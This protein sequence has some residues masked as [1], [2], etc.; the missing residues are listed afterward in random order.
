MNVLN[1]ID[2]SRL[3]DQSASFLGAD[4]FIFCFSQSPATLIMPMERRFPRR[5]AK[6]HT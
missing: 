4:Q 2:I 3:Y 1:F 6:K 5:G